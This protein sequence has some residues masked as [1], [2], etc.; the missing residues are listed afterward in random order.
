MKPR[1]IYGDAAAAQAALSAIALANRAASPAEDP[2]PRA[3]IV[4]DF[5]GDHVGA[6]ERGTPQLALRNMLHAVVAR[7]ERV[8]G[9]CMH[10]LR[11]ACGTGCGR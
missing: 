3:T 6:P 8:P 7:D 1:G 10:G 4:Y 5:T 11:I 2:V 9:L